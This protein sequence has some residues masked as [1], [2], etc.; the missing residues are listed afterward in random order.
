MFTIKLCDTV[1]GIN[2]KH[3][4]T[5]KMCRN[6]LCGSVPE[7]TVT[8]TADDI[9]AQRSTL[10]D[11]YDDGYLESLCVYRKICA[12]LVPK[13][14]MLLHAC[15]LGMD[16]R[17]YAFLAP[18]GTGKTT[19]ARM[20]ME[21]YGGRVTVINGDKP[22]VSLLG[23]VPTV[24]GTP[25]CGKEEWNTNTSMPLTALCFIARGSGNVIRR[26][27]SHDA[28]GRIMN[29]ILL[30]RDGTNISETLDLTDALLTA[31]P[32]YELT[33]TIS[34]DAAVVAHDGMGITDLP[35]IGQL[36]DEG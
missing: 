23:D 12:A 32:S 25:W 27:T 3:G 2:C 29:Q 4:Y 11:G 33:C 7:I 30:I 31:V 19:H 5:E 21:K 36:P 13:K 6:Y 10:G 14:I 26:I 8:V 15:V 1:I 9:A 24:Y 34:P 18:S 22:L 16:G 35:Y 17:A 28:A 20:W